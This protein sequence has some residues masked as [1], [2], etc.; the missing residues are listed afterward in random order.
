MAAKGTIAKQ[1]VM[2]KI[3]EA[4]GEDFI[5]EVDKK[6]YVWGLENGE[7]VQ[8]ALAMTCPKT[9]VVTGETVTVVTGSRLDFE[10]PTTVPVVNRVATA[11][12][13]SEERETVA[14]MMARLGL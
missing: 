8:I 1:N 3:Q 14:A 4:F 11:E 9:P 5:G 12:I 7:R 2:K 10:A 13:T 6:I